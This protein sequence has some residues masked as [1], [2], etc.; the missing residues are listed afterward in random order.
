[1]VEVWSLVAAGIMISCLIY[2]LIRISSASLTIAIG[3]F[4]IFIIELLT[5]EISSYLVTSPVFRDFAFRPIYLSTGDSIYTLFTSI[6]LHAGFI[7]IIINALVLVFL[8]IFLE[9]RI[10][11]PRFLI[12]FVVAGIG[13]SLT[14]GLLNWNQI[15][16]AIGASGA[17]SG[18]LGAM[19]ILYPRER[20]NFIVGFIPLRNMPMWVVILIFLG[21]QLLF[22]NPS[23]GIAWEGHI[24]GLLTGML[25]APWITRLSP[26]ARAA[27]GE[28]AD[29]ML[30]AK[31]R[32]E[33]E[34]ARQIRSESIEDV[35]RAWIDKLAETAECPVCGAR[36][37]ANRGRLKCRNGHKFNL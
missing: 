7:H 36:M 9:E 32:E 11:T 16:A 33:R 28:K 13:G 2:P 31:T 15:T 14:Y 5:I 12:I 21:L 29:V 26:E 17:I 1:M 3:L 25:I 35:R 34:I 10:G 20:M 8:G 19:G 22:V 27:R 24:G 18:I 4:L 37:R 30:F 23:S 6:F